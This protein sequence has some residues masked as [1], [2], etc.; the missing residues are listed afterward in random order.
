MRS[1]KV[2][3]FA[4]LAGMAIAGPAFAADPAPAELYSYQ[5]LDGNSYFAVSV[6]GPAL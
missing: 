6:K 1:L 5:A 3:A 4:W 2:N